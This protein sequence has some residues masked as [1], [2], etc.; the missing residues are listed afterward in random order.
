M[1]SS[2]TWSEILLRHVNTHLYSFE[3]R[4]LSLMS[5]INPLHAKVYWSFQGSA[6]F[7]DPFADHFCNLSFTSVWT[8]DSMLVLT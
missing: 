8:F 7:A 6:T 4:Y 5:I 2:D 3:N 1:D